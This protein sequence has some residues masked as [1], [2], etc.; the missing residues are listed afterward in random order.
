M[1][2]PGSLPTYYRHKYMLSTTAVRQ[3]TDNL[4]L[5]VVFTIIDRCQDLKRLAIIILS[6][7]HKLAYRE[8]E[9][10]FSQNVAVH[11]IDLQWNVL[12]L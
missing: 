1:L 8:S 12:I 9:A 3:S 11:K 4:D 6:H 10:Y 5:K 2:P 7:F